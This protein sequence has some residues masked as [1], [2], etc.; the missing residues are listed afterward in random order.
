[1][2]GNLYTFSGLIIGV[3]IGP[4]LLLLVLG[5]ILLFRKMK[6]RKVRVLKQ[7]YFKQS[8]GHLLQQLVSQEADIAERMIIPVDELAKATNNFDKARELGGGGHMVLFTKG[9]YQTYM[10]W[11]SRSQRLRSRKK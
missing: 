1:M 2:I 5:I 7:K 11:P 10:S 9:F 3:A 6:H 4:T 8:R